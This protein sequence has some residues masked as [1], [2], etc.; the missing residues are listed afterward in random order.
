MEAGRPRAEW[1]LVGRA[2]ELGL[3]RKIRTSG[4]AASAV[5]SG[6]A[7][8]GKSRLA[9]AALAEA[10][11]EG[12]AT[13]VIRGSAGMAM[14]PLGPF[15]AVLGIPNLAEVTELTRAVQD[16]LAARR[17]PK[18][19]VVLADDCQELDEVS[20][21]L[22]H[23][24]VAAAGLVLLATAR[25][26][27]PVPTPITDLWKDGLAERIELQNLSLRETSEVLAVG[28]GGQVEDTS[29]NRFWQ[30]TEGNPLYL[31]EV[32]LSSQETDALQ[33]VDGVWRWRGAW[34][35]GSRLQEIVAARLGRLD[36][37]EAT[38]IEILALS[39][40]LPLE[41]VTD[42]TS[43]RAVENLESRG[44]VTIEASGRRLEVA[45]AQPLHAEVLRSKI[46]ALQQR[47]LRKTLVEALQST[48]A[49]RAQ[50][51]VRMAC[52]SLASG[53]EVDPMTLT[54]GSDASLFGIAQA[55]AARLNEIVPEAAL[56]AHGGGP[57]VRQDHDMAIELARSAYERT[58]GLADGLRLANA[59][60]WSGATGRG[61]A[62]LADLA[63]KAE[64]VDDRL[65]LGAALGWVR[66]W[67]RYDV[68]GARNVLQAA[69]DTAGSE[70][71][72]VLLAEIHQ[73]LAGIALNTAQP[74]AALE[75][76][77]K[78]A[79]DL[80]VALSQSICAAPAAAALSYLGRCGEALALIDEAVPTANEQGHPLAVPTLLFT[81]AAVLRHMGE[82]QQAKEL[83]TWL[84]DVALSG[85]LLD[86]TAAFG[87]V[88]G[89]ILLGQGSPASAARIFRDAC[90]LLAERDVFGYEP[91]ALAGLARSR[92]EVGQE[93][94]A[95]T[96]LEEAR[97]TQSIGRHFEITIYL[98]E[99]ELHHLAGRSAAAIRAARDG[100]A[101]ARDAGMV[102]DEAF[103]VDAWLRLAPSGELAER[104]LELAS[105][106]DSRL[107]AGLAEHG[108]ALVEADPQA[109]LDVS[110]QFADMTAWSLAAEA[111]GEAARIFDRRH[112]ARA[113]RAASAEA[114]SYASRCEGTRSLM[115]EDLAGPTR[116]TR[117]EREI[118]QLA[119]AGKSNKDI[120]VAMYLSPR[121]V[122]NHL[123]NAYVKLGVADRAALADALAELKSAE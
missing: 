23:Q 18:G 33:E 80:G 52:W 86:A 77:R 66:F 16:E 37:D 19:L 57:A 47:S 123:Y 104:L 91:W 39:G 81:R 78:A 71:D 82:L 4:P 117:R 29:A 92:A 27:R 48:G 106:T 79:D 46:P 83:A 72:P 44:L 53:V 49:R 9:A 101:W 105:K 69:L 121:T 56:P 74:A 99:V 120:A 122:E 11:Q 60:V 15:R 2:E 64:N 95:T 59:L 43:S 1:P 14:V 36:P 58:G 35:G 87:V 30:I 75:L 93:A 38:A 97:R 102:I 85:E 51:R 90:G 40:S 88:L 55:I 119:A 76:A 7:G 12:W 31:R 100:A 32:V 107:V 61:E 94:Q 89:E 103:A 22:L 116:L 13:I 6:P 5:I 84:R 41:L 113:A 70:G 3:L 24:Q 42:L 67:G 112:Q 109:L 28:L 65:R 10:D 62:L 25:S 8:V 108:R 21:G 115:L 26:D 63:G 110:K 17:S 50:D 114:T 45:V 20:A 73:Q 111:A 98:A 96:A 68:E 34:A 118:A 54:M